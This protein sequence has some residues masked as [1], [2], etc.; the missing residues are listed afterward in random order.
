VSTIHKF[1]GREADIVIVLQVCR[2]IFPLSH[3]YN[4][5]FRIFG[6]SQDAILSEEIRIFYVAITRAKEKIYLLTKAG[7]ESMYI[8][9]LMK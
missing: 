4:T 2:K 8:R 9:M 3:P 1:K 5:L 7:N 6:W